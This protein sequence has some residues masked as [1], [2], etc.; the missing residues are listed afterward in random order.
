MRQNMSDC[1]EAKY[2]GEMR[3]G[4]L[5]GMVVGARASRGQREGMWWGEFVTDFPQPTDRFQLHVVS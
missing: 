4:R 5:G 3:N 2:V 1:P